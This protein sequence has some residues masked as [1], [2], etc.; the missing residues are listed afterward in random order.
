MMGHKTTLNQIMQTEIMPSIFSDHYTWNWKSTVE[1]KLE[2]HKYIEIKQ[3]NTN[4]WQS[5]R[6]IKGRGPYMETN[7]NDNT[8]SKFEGCSKKW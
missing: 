7:D 1:R 2:K 6:R 4:Q 8:T 3:H 5:Q